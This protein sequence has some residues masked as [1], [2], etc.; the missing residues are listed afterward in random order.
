MTSAATAPPTCSPLRVLFVAGSLGQGGAEKQLTYMARA[1][2]ESGNE[3]RVFSVTRDEY[4]QATLERLGV[5][6]TLANTARSRSRR[7]AALLKETYRFA[8]HVLQAS[9]FFMNPYVGVA[10][11][12]HGALGVG[13]IRN[14]GLRGMN[15]LG[16]ARW[17][18][19]RVPDGLIANS[20]LATENAV[21]AGLQLRRI[22]VLPNVIDVPAFDK[23]VADRRIRLRS[24]SEV[25]VVTVGRLVDVKRIDRFLRVLAQARKHV[26]TLRG[27]VIGDGDN[28]TQLLRLATQL[29]LLPHAVSFL[30]SRDDVPP[31][32]AAADIMLL[33]SDSEGFPNAILEAMAAG[34][35]VASTPAGDAA[36]IVIDGRTGF[37]VDFEN[38]ELMA[39]RL[40]QLARSAPLRARLGQAGRRRVLEQYSFDGLAQRLLSAY[41]SLASSSGRSRKTLRLLR[42]TS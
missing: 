14:D 8:P 7:L 36:R 12:L 6:V 24:S 25:V 34:L 32:L 31:L 30:G 15:A 26:V 38:V 35:P 9:H 2:A 23:A 19:L 16:R 28:T 17:L 5:P 10:A 42:M 29:G 20:H 37:V 4:Y 13:A 33:T 39:A 3:V 41:R 1:L 27:I 22:V 21:T 40:V 18:A 11:R